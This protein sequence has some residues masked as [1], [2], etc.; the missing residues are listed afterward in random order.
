MT[1][2]LNAPSNEQERR[3]SDLVLDYLD[4]GIALPGE[5]YTDA[6]LFDAEMDAVFSRQWVYAGH[7]SQIP[8][9]RGLL[10]R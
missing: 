6:A 4:R 2:T 5:L 1:T 3:V 10:H 9:G 8:I 7:V